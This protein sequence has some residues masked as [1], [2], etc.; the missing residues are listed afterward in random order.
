MALSTLTTNDESI[1]NSSNFMDI[2]LNF[3]VNAEKTRA[4]FRLGTEHEIFAVDRNNKPLDYWGENGIESILKKICEQPDPWGHAF[5]PVYEDSH[6]VAL[7]SEGSSVTLEPGG[8][9]ELSGNQC[10]SAHESTHEIHWFRHT[11]E[12]L[13]P[14]E[15]QFITLGFHPSARR[16]DFIW[17]PKQRYQIMRN[18]MPK[19]GTLGIDMMLRTCTVQANLDYESE[20]DM[21][22]SARTAFAISPIVAALFVS[23]PFKEAKPSGNLSERIHT[24]TDTDNDRCGYPGIVFADDFGYKKWIEFALDVPMYFVRRDNRYVDM[25]GRSFRTF[26]ND[27]FDG[28]QATLGDFADHLTT[29]FTEVRIKPYLETRSADCGPIEHLCALPALWKGIL[30]DVESRKKAW[31][32]M[33]EPSMNEL[34]ELHAFASK[35][36][37]KARYRGRTLQSLAADLLELSRA[38]LQRQNVLNKDGF[39]ETIYLKPL[40]EMVASGQSYAE[41]LLA[42]NYF[43]I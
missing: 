40:F 39:N 9:I 32:L 27:G 4:N 21:V 1:L 22:E 10:H 11:L 31:Q 19:K 38:G 37:L 13:S 8:Q 12:Q 16:E 20:A 17:V 7:Q 35:Q 3:F 36:A 2:A 33:Q 29:I 34:S 24:W 6:I 26:I 23:S 5:N 15:T 25:S 42:S 18:Y 41:K 30:Y 14:A 28:L 43:G